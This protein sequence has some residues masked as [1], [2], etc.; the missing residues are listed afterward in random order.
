[1]NAFEEYLQ[2]RGYIKLELGSYRTWVSERWHRMFVGRG[3]V[4]QNLYQQYVPNR[5]ILPEFIR[6][7]DLYDRAQHDRDYPASRPLLLDAEVEEIRRIIV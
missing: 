6:W 2:E 3:L 1:M 4:R 5:G 7:L